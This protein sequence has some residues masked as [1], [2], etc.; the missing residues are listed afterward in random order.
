MPDG[1]TKPQTL[2]RGLSLERR[3]TLERSGEDATF[4]ASLS[5][6]LPCERWFGTEILSHAEGA[7][8]MERAVNGLSLLFNHDVDKPVGRCG[9][10]RVDGKRLVGVFRFSP[11]SELG[12]QIQKEVEGGFLQDVSIRYSIDEYETKTD[13]HGHDTVTITRW[14]PLEV[15]I[16]T[17]P[18]DHTVGVGRSHHTQEG[19]H[20]TTKTTATGGEGNDGGIVNVVQFRE[21]HERGLQQ[22]RAEAARIERERI[23]EIDALFAGCRFTGPAYDALRAECIKNGSNTE[24]ARRALFDLVNG[25]TTA[26]AAEPSGTRAQPDAVRQQRDPFVQA[27]ESADEKL[28]TGLQR[29]LE[30]RAKMVTGAEAAREGGA[31][32][33]AG[34]S[35]SEMARAFAERKGY[36][37][38]G[39][40]RREVIGLVFR[41]GARAAAGMGTAEF[42]SILANVANK[43]LL[44]GW[45]ENQTTWREVCRVG[46]LN[47]F[48]RTNRTGLSGADLLDVVVEHG[49]Y[50]Y[51]D[52]SDRTEYITAG[53]YGK[54]FSITREAIINDDLA[55]FTTI[56]RKMGRAAD[57]TVNKIFVDLLCSNSGVG[58]TLN[59]DSTALFRTSGSANYTTSSGAPTVANLEV[60]RNLMARQTDPNNGMPLNIQ[61]AIL[62]VPSALVTTGKVLVGSEKDPT[63]SLMGTSSGGNTSINPFYNALKVVGEPYLDDTS[64][65]NGTVAWYLFGDPNRHDTFE[66]AFVDGQQTPYMESRD[67]WSVDGVDYK[68]RIEFGVAALD[69]R[70]VYRKRGA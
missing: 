37:V 55:A 36:R 28:A 24:Q 32:E 49:E 26:P 67:G 10:I 38:A 16:V 58:P 20:V 18:A 47:D 60:G 57:L 52:M 66:V 19:N 50:K 33:F 70:A 64:H 44:M 63:S 8:N 31:N 23:G 43:A 13:E 69:Y 11:H 12:R 56:P 6:E 14:T 1:S 39:M 48:R 3:F 27:G 29:A 4:R 42:T 9:D 34:L 54:L 41:E 59:Q 15:S 7:V 30:V 22:G 46:S 5:S 53:K 21:A 17:V 61:P 62:Y 40:S 51:G 25:D 35:L 65:T 68:V 2:Q 45:E